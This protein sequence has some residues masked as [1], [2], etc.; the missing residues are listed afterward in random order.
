M[1]NA[2]W[3]TLLGLLLLAV[4]FSFWLLKRLPVTTA[5]VY[6]VVGLI[7]GPTGLYLFHF[8][9]L[10]QSA[11]LE[12]IAEGAVLVSLFSAGLKFQLP[13]KY[14]RWR[15]P[16]RL[17]LI[18]MTASVGLMAAFGHWLM[19]MSWG[20]AVLLG[21][22][23]AP[24]DP[25]L[26]TEVQ[27]RHPHDHERLRFGLTGEAGLNDGT[28][29]PFV[30]LGLGLLGLHEI[31]PSAMR[32]LWLDVIWACAAGVAF[33]V[34]GGR[35]MAHAIHRLRSRLASEWLPDFLGLGFVGV[36]YGVT[37]LCHAYGF[38]AVFVAAVTLRQTEQRLMRDDPGGR[39]G[40]MS[41]SGHALTFNEQLERL[42]ELA[43]VVLIGGSLFANS[44]SWRA[45]ACAA[46][47]FLVAR[48]VSVALG[49]AGSAAPARTRQMMAWFGVRGIGS[50]YYLMFAIRHGV[51]QPVGL[52][53]LSITLI[54][55][56]LSIFLHGLSA[57]PSMAWYSRRTA[58]SRS[59]SR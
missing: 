9:P 54:V 37:V 34:A 38:L 16:I 50:L 11:V 51:P 40:T 8:N 4:G 52:D 47:L 56:T 2:T 1:S 53:I 20:A 13:L 57:R 27:I 12:V 36:V 58:T 44:W 22:I 18:S 21:A 10:K 59:A 5:M 35:I 48:P 39:G 30:M 6:L 3:F 7:V 24:T 28:A 15:L 31:G 17:A 14:A 41:M 26:A 19:G 55:I 29:F 32:W 46:F 45:V 42:S 33:G 49:L 43:L 23:L 25:V